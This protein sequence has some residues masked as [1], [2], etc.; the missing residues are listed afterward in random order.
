MIQR[1]PLWRLREIRNI[2][3]TIAF[4][5]AHCPVPAEAMAL[6]S[7][8]LKPEAHIHLMIDPKLEHGEAIHYVQ[9]RKGAVRIKDGASV[10]LV[11]VTI[12][13]NADL[14]TIA[15]WRKA[16]RAVLEQLAWVGF[17]S[18]EAALRPCASTSDSEEEQMVD[19]FVDRTMERTD[20]Q[21]G[22]A[23]PRFTLAR[24]NQ[25]VEEAD[26][27]TELLKQEIRP[28]FQRLL[29]SYLGADGWQ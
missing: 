14:S 22:A 23:R 9:K 19:A 26:G 20:R 2:A 27:F 15:G 1:I 10:D 8:L 21:F 3:D 25:L 18:E 29:S 28:H 6:E 5:A 16:A 7:K 11:R 13:F 4:R 24:L 12:C 17:F